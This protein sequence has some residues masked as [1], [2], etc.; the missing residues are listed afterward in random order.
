MIVKLSSTLKCLLALS[1]CAFQTGWGDDLLPPMTNGSPDEFA[2]RRTGA[3]FGAQRKILVSAEGIHRI[4]YSSLIAA[5]ISNPVGSQLRLFWRTQEIALATSSQGPWS[6]GDY[7]LFYGWPNSG[8]WSSNNVYWLAHTGFGLRMQAT[9]ASENGSWPV[10]TTHW[11]TVHYDKKQIFIPFYRP[12][13][14]RF[15]HWISHNVFSHAETNILI[16]TPDRLLNATASVHAMLWGRTSSPAHD[17]DHQT[18]FSING[19]IVQTSS[20]DGAV[21]HLAQFSV[22]Q[23]LFSNGWNTFGFRQVFTAVSDVVSIEWVSLCYRASNRISEGVLSFW[24]ITGS[25]TY[26]AAGWNTNHFPW[27]FDVTDPVR[28]VL[29]T[30]ISVLSM[31]ATGTVRWSWSSP[32]SNRFYLANSNAWIPAAISPPIEFQNLADTN[33]RSDYII[34]SAPP[35]AT[36]AYALARFRARQGFR[37]LIVP[38]ENVF[39]EFSYGVRD[40]RAIKQ[41]LGYAYH[42][43]AQRPR[44]VVLVGDGSYDPRNRMNVTSPVDLIPVWLGPSAYDFCAQDGWY[45]CV[46]GPD[47]LRDLRIGR[48]P[49]ST[50]DLVS[51]AVARIIQYE[52]ASP[53]ASWRSKALAVADTNQAPNFFQTVSDTFVYTNLLLAGV[54]T[55]TRAYYNGMNSATVVSTITNVINAAHPGGPVFSV[56]YFGHGWNNDWAV[57]FNVSHAST[58]I[59]SASQPFFTIWTCANGAFAHPTNQSM[60]ERLMER[61][62]NRGAS[63]VLSASAL[64][65]NEA[66]ARLADGFYSSFTN[67]G[68]IRLGEAMD[69]AFLSLFAFSPESAEHLFYNLFGDPAHVVRP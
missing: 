29:L 65:L 60:A 15:D 49:F 47:L 19:T 21:G 11:R 31:G 22:P 1:V 55:R 63:A 32:Q 53:S 12:M 59:N 34:L 45:A 40:A 13:D 50:P 25:S 36:A 56:S 54:P 39:D 41:F 8:Y 17:P 9:N 57:G 44:Y 2:P 61:P 52:S 67:S 43:W 62:P 42:H 66:A 33:R 64:S 6:A 14:D 10:V 46:D 27:L 24:G 23:T 28:P 35:L 7:A 58:L 48:F 5:G 69:R 26:A 20:F 38:I 18:R 3:S 68:P 30:N 51:N 37:P 4:D 16:A